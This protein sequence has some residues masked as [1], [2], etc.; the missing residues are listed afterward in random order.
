MCLINDTNF[1]TRSHSKLTLALEIQVINVASK[2]DFL[3]E[4]TITKG[5]GKVV[6]GLRKMPI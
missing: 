2:N 5:K 6:I 4:N 3:S 1:H